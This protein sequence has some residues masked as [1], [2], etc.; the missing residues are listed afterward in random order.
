M[1]GAARVCR[2]VRQGAYGPAASRVRCG[3][4]LFGG[5]RRTRCVEQVRLR[6]HP[7]RLE[8]RRLG[9]LVERRPLPHG[10]PHGR[11]G[12]LLQ[13][14]REGGTLRFRGSEERQH[15]RRR[16]R[17]RLHH[18]TEGGHHRARREVQG[19]PAWRRRQD[20]RR[21]QPLP[22]G[23]QDGEGHL[24]RLLLECERGAR[25]RCEGYAR[26]G[27]AHAEACE[28]ARPARL[29]RAPPRERQHARLPPGRHHRIHAGPPDRLAVHVCR[30]A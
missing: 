29:R 4:R 16:E 11:H 20:A 3:T 19:R 25:I 1:R 14:L 17:N 7:P 2:L 9:L 6:Q 18:R 21:P 27:A 26:M 12:A 28:R 8:A 13:A 23:P 5:P 30:R 22:H 10:H 15:R 24:S